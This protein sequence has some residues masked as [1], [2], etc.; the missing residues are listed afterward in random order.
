MNTDNEVYRAKEHE[1]KYLD[2]HRMRL[3][4][5]KA[6]TVTVEFGTANSPLYQSSPID[7][8][9]ENLYVGVNIDPAQHAFLNTDVKKVD[10]FAT[11]AKVDQ[12]G[13]VETLLPDESS[14]IVFMANV[15]GE[16]NDENIGLGDTFPSDN[17]K[18]AGHS[19][20]EAKAKTLE[21][22]RRV[23]KPD[24]RIV[25]LETNTPFRNW[26]RRELGAKRQPVYSGMVELLEDNGYEISEALAIGDED[27]YEAIGQFA[28]PSEWWD[29]RSS[30]L[31][32]AEK[33]D[34]EL[35]F[36]TEKD[37]L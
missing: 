26:K 1:N 17:N 10:G 33:R 9:E 35:G 16:P 21:E 31:V 11:V 12:A 24:G 23:L 34:K 27:W 4:M 36:A 29:N 20:L 13:N 32:V 25:I 5:A 7:F 15:F 22:A 14:D 6:D 2:V 37:Y 30:Y 19:S 3:A 18:Y 8:N 28:V